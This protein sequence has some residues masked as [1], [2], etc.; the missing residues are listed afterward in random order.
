MW[1][2]TVSD[3]QFEF[4]WKEANSRR[5][6]VRIFFIIQRSVPV[7]VRRRVIE[8]RPAVGEAADTKVDFALLKAVA[9]A[10]Q[11]LTELLSGR[12]GSLDEI[13]KRDGVG[14]R[15]VSRIIRLA[16]LAPS[17]IEEIAR[18]EQTPELTAQALSTRCG[19][20][21]LNR[22]EQRELLGL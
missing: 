15:Y 8:M 6:Q 14:K 1:P 5:Q 13:G 12:S 2:K 3:F 11:W 17:I 18:G 22:W 7:Q 19:D 10:D 9:R 21:P 4:R 20:L 16:F